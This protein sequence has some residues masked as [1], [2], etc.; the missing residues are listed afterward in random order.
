MYQAASEVKEALDVHDAQQA[1]AVLAGLVGDLVEWYLPHRPG[2]GREAVQ[3][4]GRL[5]A[6]FVPYLAEAIHRQLGG[7]K[8]QSVHLDAWPTVEPSWQDE[9][10]L[11]QMARLSVW[12]PWPETL[13]AVL[14]CRL[15][16][17]CA[18]HSSWL[19][20]GR[21]RCGQPGAIQ[22]P[23]GGSDGRGPGPLYFRGGSSGGL[24][25]PPG[26]GAHG[27]AESLSRPIWKRLWPS[28]VQKRWR[29]GVTARRGLERS[30]QGWLARCS[31]FCL[32]RY[33]LGQKPDQGGQRRR[34]QLLDCL[35]YWRW[36]DRRLAVGCA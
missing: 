5:L 3:V 30:V 2:R 25:S 34:M 13:V 9:A 31:R 26:P 35:S 19:A 14:G 36:T 4:L 15:S 11:A 28:Y 27:H 16:T 29:I 8:V 24:A 12:W 18:R 21:R 33:K 7:Q 22:P 10:L 6:P 32:T 20:R 23:L 17:S 1:A